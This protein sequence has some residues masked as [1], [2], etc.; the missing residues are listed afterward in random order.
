MT[1][2]AF[3]LYVFEIMKSSSNYSNKTIDGAVWRDDL[4]VFNSYLKTSIILI[5]TI[6]LQ[7]ANSV[8]IVMSFVCILNEKCASYSVALLLNGID[9]SIIQINSINELATWN[10]KCHCLIM[11]KGLCTNTCWIFTMTT[12]HHRKSHWHGNSNKFRSSV[13]SP[14]N[15]NRI[16]VDKFCL[17]KNRFHWYFDLRVEVGLHV[18]FWLFSFMS[19]ASNISLM[20]FLLLVIFPLLV[21]KKL[22]SYMEKEN[23]KTIRM[24]MHCN[25][26]WKFIHRIR[27]SRNYTRH[28][29]STSRTFHLYP[30]NIFYSLW[31]YWYS[32]VIHIPSSN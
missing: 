28:E 9:G 25:F 10:S 1:D 14:L 23:L 30:I 8:T 20:A 5:W 11:N 18:R 17:F 6:M 2:A 24:E 13:D 31:I 4:F 16:Q 19:D 29:R 3:F 26:L 21:W 32:N 22:P 12:D 15:K 7:I 27:V